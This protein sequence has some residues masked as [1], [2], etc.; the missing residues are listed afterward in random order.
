MSSELFDLGMKIRREVLGDDYVDASWATAKEDGFTI[1]LQ[2]LATEFAWGAVWGREALDRR[3]RSLVTIAMLIALNRPNEI[4]MHVRAAIKNGCSRE[5]IQE[6]CIN[7]ACYC[8]FP[9][10]IDAS[11]IAREVLKQ[12]RTEPA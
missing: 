12:S 1:P 2:T 9:A 4:A 6:L 8:G 3:T 11:R 7:A 10:A 5:D